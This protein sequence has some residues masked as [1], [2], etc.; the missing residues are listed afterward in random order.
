MLV[1]TLHS[2]ATSSTLATSCARAANNCSAPTARS[3]GQGFF[4]LAQALATHRPICQTNDLAFYDAQPLGALAEQLAY[5]GISI[6]W[7]WSAGHHVWPESTRYP[8]RLGKY[9]DLL[10]PYLLGQASRPGSIN[11]WV[12]VLRPTVPLEL[13]A[14]PAGPDHGTPRDYEFWIPGLRFV[15]RVG[16]GADEVSRVCLTGS[17]IQTLC[18]VDPRERRSFA[19]IVGLVRG[20]DPKGRLATALR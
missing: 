16:G 15:V 6:I 4:A 11:V 9:E 13:L 19:A 20:A 3:R 1:S 5:F 14:L 2:E 7:R 8:R 10:R 12:E 18:Q 17:T